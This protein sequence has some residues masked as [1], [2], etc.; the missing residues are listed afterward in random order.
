MRI[1]RINDAGHPLNYSVTSSDD[2]IVPSSEEL[3][4]TDDFSWYDEIVVT[5]YSLQDKYLMST[6]Q[7]KYLMSLSTKLLLAANQRLTIYST[8]ELVYFGNDLGE[9]DGARA[10]ASV[11]GVIV[12]RCKGVIIS[13]NCR[14]IFP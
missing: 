7:D 10:C 13:S 1:G 12:K 4:M 2:I 9:G 6:L 5:F 14:F 3:M 11:S 8:K